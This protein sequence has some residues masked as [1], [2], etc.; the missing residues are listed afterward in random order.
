MGPN[1]VILNITATDFQPLSQFYE[2]YVIQNVITFFKK[3]LMT[4]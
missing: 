4:F 3:S 1:T 2:F